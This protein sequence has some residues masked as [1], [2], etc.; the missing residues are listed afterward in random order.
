M[1]IS[2]AALQAVAT[3]EELSG[4][5]AESIHVRPL[6]KDKMDRLKS[7]KIYFYAFFGFEEGSKFLRD[8]LGQELNITTTSSAK[9]REGCFQPGSLI[10]DNAQ[11]R[12]EAEEM[13]QEMG[14]QLLQD[15]S[16][17]DDKKREFAL[18][19]DNAQQL[20]V[21][22]YNTPTCTLPIF[23]KEGRYKNKDK[24]KEWK[25]LFPRQE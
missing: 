25:P 9:K 10:F 6:P 8:K 13:A 18:G 14:F 19:Y 12:K 1:T 24:N 4:K 3:F 20:I 7:C 16:W 17:G 23:W 22:Q 21:F 15:K 5:R 2:Q 11:D